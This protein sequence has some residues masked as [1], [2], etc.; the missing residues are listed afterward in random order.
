[1]DG[2]L[3]L[4]IGTVLLLIALSVIVI[5]W[6]GLIPMHRRFNELRDE[7]RSRIDRDSDR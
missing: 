6:R 2:L 3:L 7:V 1:M 5:V 4:V